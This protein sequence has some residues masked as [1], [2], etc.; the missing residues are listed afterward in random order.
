[1]NNIMYK[2]VLKHVDICKKK[3]GCMIY[4]CRFHV[5]EYKARGK[6]PSRQIEQ[7]F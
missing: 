4:L 2:A 3:K 7:K 6:E 1:M 5:I